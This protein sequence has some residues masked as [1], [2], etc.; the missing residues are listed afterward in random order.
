MGL[1]LIIFIVI[2]AIS[3]ISIALLYF[4]K[5]PKRNNIIFTCTVAIGILISYLNITSLPSNFVF[6][7]IVAVLFGILAV[8]GVLLKFKKWDH[9]A[10]LLVTT[11]VVLGVFQLFFF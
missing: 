8:I 5:D 4:V 3:C 11:S 6:P 7:R 2:A 10:K 1:L 9:A